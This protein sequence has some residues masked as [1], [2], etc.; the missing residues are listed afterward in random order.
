M[1]ELPALRGDDSLGFLA[2]VGLSALGEQGEIPPIMLRWTEESAPTAVVHGQYDSL[3]D[4]AK[5]IKTAFQKLRLH[6][7]VLPGVDPSLPLA[8]KGSGPDPM[9][10]APSAMRELF[11]DASQRWVCSGNPWPARWL[12]AL[13]TQMAVDDDGRIVLTPFYAPTGQMAM[14]TSIFENTMAA[15]ET[16]D[17]PAD[18]LD[19]W[20]RTAFDAA[21]FDE[22]AKRDAAVTTY[23][24][25]NNQG[26]PS[27][28]WLAAM[29]LR[30]FPLVERG[31][32]A[33]APGWQRVRLYP[34]YT[35]RSLIWPTWRQPLDADAVR[36][37]L[38]HSALEAKGERHEPR[39]PHELR[40]LGV[41]GL[42][43]SSRRTSSQGD[44]PLGPTIRLW[45]A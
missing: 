12:M 44:G 22:R 28:T 27:P 17:G 25:A 11:E 19:G 1:I 43:G 45:S 26:A 15:V 35:A 33:E 9:R 32:A 6:D 31:N 34:R 8:K 30:C 29:A 18:A 37:L 24:K 7:A 23:G 38:S 42:Y 10:M 39:R 14:R 40:A 3:D 36:T 5:A 4:L 20:K 21:N 16:I 13:C 41:T 2:A